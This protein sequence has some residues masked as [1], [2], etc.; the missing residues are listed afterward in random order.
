MTRYNLPPADDPSSIE[1]FLRVRRSQLPGGRPPIPG[2]PR[3]GR[4]PQ[5]RARRRADRGPAAS[6][7]RRG[8][9]PRRRRRSGGA[10]GGPVRLVASARAG[11]QAGG[12][13]PRRPARRPEQPG[14]SSSGPGRDRG[15]RPGRGSG[16]A[17]VAAFA[18]GRPAS[19]R[20]ARRDVERAGGAPQ[21]PGPGGALA[22]PG[23]VAGPSGPQPAGEWGVEPACSG[24]TR[25]S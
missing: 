6:H 18:C 20:P 16:P 23:R 1:S 21:G 25:A 4:T 13:R 17:A 19:K 8:V 24:P 7:A 9:R 12:R 5:R 3:G 11:A 14:P 22:G 10:E 15:W 2:H